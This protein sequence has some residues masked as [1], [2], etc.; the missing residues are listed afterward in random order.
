MA[1]MAADTPNAITSGSHTDSALNS[2]VW[3]QCLQMYK[4]D[5][6]LN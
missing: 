5:D 2:T 3:M 1:A 6:A 4:W